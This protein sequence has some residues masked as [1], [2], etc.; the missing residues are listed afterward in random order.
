MPCYT[1]P[2][3]ELNHHRSRAAEA[4][5]TAAASAAVAPTVGGDPLK[6]FMI[7]PDEEDPCRHSLRYAGDK[8]EGGLLGEQG[9]RE[10]GAGCGML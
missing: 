10:Q 1:L 6:T 4:A 5:V 3:R 9:C 7:S 8:N 2:L